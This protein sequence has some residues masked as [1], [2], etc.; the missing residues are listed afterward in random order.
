METVSLVKRAI[1]YILSGI[2]YSVIG[3]GSAL[4]FLLILNLNIWIYIAIGL[5]FSVVISILFSYLILLISKGY[6]IISFFFGVKVV[7]V[8][9]KNITSKQAIIRA[10]NENIVIFT[11]IDLVYLISHRTE[12]GVV[13][14]LSD[15]F[16]IDT[17]R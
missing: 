7:G 15:T 16:M 17:R 14:R 8:E 4:P 1:I 5:G 12:R 10:F 13:D 11:I 6:T 3:Y 9:E 2:L